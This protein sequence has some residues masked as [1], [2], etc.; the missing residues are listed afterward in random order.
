MIFVENAISTDLVSRC[1]AEIDKFLEE[2]KFKDSNNSDATKVEQQFG[3]LWAHVSQEI[4][5]EV[6]A[7]LRPHFPSERPRY[8]VRYQIHRIG[9]QEF[10]HD[11]P[12]S[13]AVSLYL[14]DFPVEWGGRF[15]Y[16]PKNGRWK[17]LAVSP[18]A[19]MMG[20]INNNEEHCVTTI[21]KTAEYSRR[22]VNIKAH[23]KA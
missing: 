2:K 8:T 3:K 17:E 9:T 13:F 14:N 7:A 11:H 6:L 5:E 20:L 18:K 12:Y 10:W 15:K 23:R 16:K 21:L 1:N 19:G 22:A 4:K